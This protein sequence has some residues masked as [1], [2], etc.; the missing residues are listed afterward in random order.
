MKKRL[1]GVKPLL[2]GR[3]CCQYINGRCYCQLWLVEKPLNVVGDV[4][5]T[6]ADGIAT[7]PMCWLFILV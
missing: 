3:C 4:V 1:V 5:A 2:F 7:G 6:V